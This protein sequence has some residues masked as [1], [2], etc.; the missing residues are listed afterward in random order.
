MFQCVIYFVSPVLYIMLLLLLSPKSSNVPWIDFWLKLFYTNKVAF[1]WR[2]KK[3]RR[4]AA[5]KLFRITQVF[6]N[7]VSFE[8]KLRSV[9]QV[10]KQDFCEP[11]IKA[12]VDYVFSDVQGL[13]SWLYHRTDSWATL[14]EP[15]FAHELKH[16]S[17]QR[18]RYFS[19]PHCCLRNN[20]FVSFESIFESIWVSVLW[21]S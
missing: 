16:K 12:C 20:T 15:W 2:E 1:P 8:S 5:I 6:G 9:K 7:Y 4:G 19:V 21:R 13:T 18:G 17:Q 3:R 10:I 14:V 11:C